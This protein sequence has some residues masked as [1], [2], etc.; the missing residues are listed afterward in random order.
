VK[1]TQIGAVALCGLALACSGRKQQPTPE[2]IASRTLT[3]TAVSVAAVVPIESPAPAIVPIGSPTSTA[4]KLVASDVTQGPFLLGDQSF[5][6]IKHI[7]S[8]EGSKS[9]DD[10]MVEWWE[11]RDDRGKTVYRQQYGLNFQDKT[12]ADTEDVDARELKASFGRGILINGGSLPSA[13]NSGWWVQVFGLVNGKLSAMGAPMSTEGDFIGEEVETYQS[14]ALFRGQQ[15]RSVSR[16]LLNF[17]VW[18]GNFSIIY[19]VLIDWVQGTVRP[20]W[21]CSRMTAKGQVSACRYKVEASPVRDKEM[22]FVRLFSEPEDGFTPKH[23][24]IKPESRIDY[25]EAEAAVPWSAD[26]NN[27]S[28]GV[29]GGGQVWLHIRVDGQEGW[30]SGEEDLE[31]VGLSA[32]E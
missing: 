13:P 2:P 10:S 20:A 9:V 24:V 31:A 27:I 16:D 11:L 21:I 17:R 5:T 19:G 30:I 8:I 15:M 18:T 22:T 12:F 23:V 1:A 25:L 26:Q 14:S 3:P 7:Q 6:F 4:P 28:F 29:S 32:A